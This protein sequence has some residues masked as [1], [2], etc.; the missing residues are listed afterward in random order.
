MDT[1]TVKISTKQYFINMCIITF[2]L[3]I[4]G[5]IVEYGKVWV[6]K[7]VI[8]A[9]IKTQNINSFYKI[10]STYIL[11]GTG[12]IFLNILLK[13]YL[14]KSIENY[15]YKL[16]SIMNRSSITRGHREKLDIGEITAKITD[17]VECIKT[18]YNSNLINIFNLIIYTSGSAIIL[19]RLNYKL[20]ILLYFIYIVITLLTNKINNPVKSIVEERQ[21]AT[22]KV[23]S[24]M[25]EL[26]SGVIEIKA[27]NAYKTLFT[28]YEN[29]INTYTFLNNKT[30]LYNAMNGPLYIIFQ[31]VPY[32]IIYIVGGLYVINNVITFGELILFGTF[33]GLL[34]SEVVNIPDLFNEYKKFKV[35][36]VRVNNFI[37]TEDNQEDNHSNKAIVNN[38]M[39]NMES[40]KTAILLRDI[41]VS[42]DKDNEV[43]R[44]INIEIN[45]NDKVGII[46]P[47]GCGKSTLTKVLLNEV[48]F[49]GEA[50]IYGNDIKKCS[51][52]YIRDNIAIVESDDYIFHETIKDN[53]WIGNLS[54]DESMVY[55]VAKI[56]GV[57]EFVG[58]Y[59]ERYDYVIGENGVG[60][61]VG[62]KQRICIARML[63]RNTKIIL[64]DEA[65]SALDMNME[66]IILGNIAQEYNDKTIIM[67]THR[68]N[69]LNYFNKIIRME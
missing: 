68:S 20:T 14:E 15:V 48:E 50:Y 47:S 49:S 58:N 4:V 7:D 30:V 54:Q 38:V 66:K 64:M 11:L 56:A 65:T 63:L 32:I 24:T 17:D 35:S 8:D 37:V 28:R 59:E 36:V 26:I 10:A 19:L 39:N 55:K 5:F 31:L 51:S 57:D 46:G 21:K 33:S 34:T 9:G 40:Q 42:Y 13:M 12:G 67:I 61:S 27:F 3:V 22:E 1:R 16:R 6:I 29:A 69:N 52:D 43:I 53:I 60:L 23:N 41:A 62:E 44:D 25:S 45:Q 2:M 18:F